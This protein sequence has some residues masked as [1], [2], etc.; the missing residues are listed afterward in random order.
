LNTTARGHQQPENDHLPWQ[1]ST[2]RIPI[3][4]KQ[5]VLKRLVAGLEPLLD[6]KKV[7]MKDLEW[8]SSM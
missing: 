8:C 3:V 7:V 1:E 4:Q 2:L 5:D 6:I